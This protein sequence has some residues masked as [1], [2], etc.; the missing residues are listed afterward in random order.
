[1]F[2]RRIASNPSLIARSARYPS[3]ARTVN[4]R[5]RI[6]THRFR[7]TSTNAFAGNPN[8]SN[9]TLSPAV[10]GALTGSLTTFAIGYI[11]YRRSGAKDLLAATR[12]TKDY[13]TSTKQNIKESTPE[14]NEALDWL[15]QAARSYAVFIPGARGYIDSAF[16][17]LD[18]VR[19]KHG[20]EVDKIVRETYEEL[21]E[22]TGK[23]D[24]NLETMWRAKIVDKHPQLKEKLG[25]SVDQLKQ[26]G[27]R[28]GPEAK[29]E[30]NKTWD[31]I[32]DIFN[33]G[34]SPEN[35]ENAK[36]VIQEKV[37]L[38]KKM[39]DEAWKKGME[40]AKPYLDKNPKI[41]ELVEKNQN[42]LEAS[43]TQKAKDSGFGGLEQYLNKIPGGDEIIPK[44]G[45]LQEV[46]QKHGQ[47]AERIMKEA[48]EEISQVLAKKSDEATRVAEK[49]K[50]DAKEH[51]KWF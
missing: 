31:Q 44:L 35:V 21:R 49:A 41:K 11:W 5:P 48:V 12:T 32:R 39:G 29:K 18:T 17:D 36:K 8:G 1:M 43:A 14:P 13:V 4:A 34:V 38:V 26:V 23:G 45:Q 10:I 30:V 25:G 7:S 50:E 6:R 20:D 24:M 16:D 37:E 33:T 40:Q 51:R 42:A 9:S 3:V 15:R 28:F 19:A 2:S 22:V 46:A 47:E 27:D